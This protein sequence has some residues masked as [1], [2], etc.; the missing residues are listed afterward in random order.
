LLPLHG[1]L[2]E[3]EVVAAGPEVVLRLLSPLRETAH[4]ALRDTVDVPLHHTDA[5]ERERLLLPPAS[6]LAQVTSGLYV[7]GILVATGL[8]TFCAPAQPH[9]LAYSCPLLNPTRAKSGASA[10]SGVSYASCARA[11]CANELA[12][13]PVANKAAAIT[14]P[15]V[16]TEAAFAL[17]SPIIPTH[18]AVDA[19]TPLEHADL[20]WGVCGKVGRKGKLEKAWTRHET[21]LF[22]QETG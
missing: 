5:L 10:R 16:Q 17:T 19:P 14:A 21:V 2:A 1:A 6:I 11:S 3:V 15:R 9:A 7:H 20:S 22:G 4:V 13:P 18:A 8:E 12:G